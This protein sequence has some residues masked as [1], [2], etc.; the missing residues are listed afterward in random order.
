MKENNYKRGYQYWLISID[1]AAELVATRITAQEREDDH[2][3]SILY[4]A[5]FS[6]KKRMKSEQQLKSLLPNGNNLSDKLGL[7]QWE[8][9]KNSL[10]VDTSTLK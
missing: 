9:E 3:F 7:W 2:W 4:A 10:T 1:T 8:K 6:L 5:H